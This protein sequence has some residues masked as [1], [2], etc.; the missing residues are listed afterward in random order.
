MSNSRENAIGRYNIR[1]TSAVDVRDVLPTSETVQEQGGRREDL[2]TAVEEFVNIPGTFH[3]V[4][5]PN[6]FHVRFERFGGGGAVFERKLDFFAQSVNIPGKN[7]ESTPLRIYG[8]EREIPTGVSYSGDVSLRC[9]LS[10]DFFVYRWFMNWMNEIVGEITSNVN[11]YDRYA[12]RMF[13]TPVVSTGDGETDT[14]PI[15]IVVED[16]WPKTMSQID[17]NQATKS[18]TAEFTLALSFRK[19]HYITPNK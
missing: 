10:Q 12:T 19:W 14:A 5:T 11:Y 6:A 17:L 16:V 1:R 3:G 4:Y 8:P 7:I 18:N 9:L 15:V 13:I 2:Q